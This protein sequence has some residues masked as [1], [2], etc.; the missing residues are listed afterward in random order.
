M[1]IELF[2]KKI[3]SLI[4]PY[5]RVFISINHPTLERVLTLPSIKSASYFISSGDLLYIDQ[6]DDLEKLCW[7]DY[8]LINP[9]DKRNIKYY[10]DFMKFKDLVKSHLSRGE[11][12]QIVV[13]SKII[14]PDVLH[15]AC[16][17]H[18]ASEEVSFNNDS[19][20]HV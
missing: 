14:M 4:T 1:H 9:K 20:V 7:I 11:D 16:D 18:I 19:I 12:F 15:L 5:K 2:G 6:I 17:V 10:E 3:V 8:T 13:G